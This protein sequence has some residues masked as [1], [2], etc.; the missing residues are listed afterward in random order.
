MSPTTSLRCH[1]I[2]S[3]R[4]YRAN[5]YIDR[6]HTSRIR[7]LH[8]WR[9]Q[10]RYQK[11]NEHVSRSWRGNLANPSSSTMT[12][13]ERCV[14]PGR[15][16]P[17]GCMPTAPRPNDPHMTHEATLGGPI[18]RDRLW[19]FQQRVRPVSLTLEACHERTCR[20]AD[21]LE[22]AI[23]RQSIRCLDGRPPGSSRLFQQLY[24]TNASANTAVDDRP[25]RT[26]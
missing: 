5:R 3:S 24:A 22:P 12:P 8:R 15:I 21:G 10:R 7:T 26:R 6:Q 14:A 9:R 4:R 18:V 23:R 25:V 13:L 16:T 11:R 2:C 20:Y 17:P 1:S 19:F